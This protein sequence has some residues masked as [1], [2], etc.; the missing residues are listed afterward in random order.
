MRSGRAGLKIIPR[1][2]PLRWSYRSLPQRS[3]VIRMNHD[4]N[5][6]NGSSSA[7]RQRVI[8]VA[9]PVACRDSARSSRRSLGLVASP[10]TPTGQ[11]QHQYQQHC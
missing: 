2:S 6:R 9:A 4:G 3:Q 8:A 7:A 5:A 1:P 10:P 11:G